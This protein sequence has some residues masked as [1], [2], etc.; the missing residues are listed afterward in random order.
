MKLLLD[1]NLP[2]RLKQ[3]FEEHEI[4]TVR[5]MGWNGV[6]NG[7][8]LKLMIVA[9]FQVL[10]TF[11]KNLQFQ[12]NFAKYTLPIIVLNAFD[13]TYLT[14][15]EFMPQILLLLKANLK[16]GANIITYK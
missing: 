5:D 6:K 9:E 11:D 8:L 12:Q 13:N 4:Y 1:E 3:H 16:A 14:L 15:R 10:I 7:E 2:K